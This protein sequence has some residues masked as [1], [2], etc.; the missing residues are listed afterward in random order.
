MTT[1]DWDLCSLNV[2][3]PQEFIHT[4]KTKDQRD[5]LCTAIG[6]IIIHHE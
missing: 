4:K 6:Q 5:V 2:V 3:M 1:L